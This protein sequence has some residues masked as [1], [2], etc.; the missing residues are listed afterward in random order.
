MKNKNHM[1]I[2]GGESRTVHSRGSWEPS[3]CPRVSTANEGSGQALWEGR[4][5]SKTQQAC[6]LAPWD[7]HSFHSKTHSAIWGQG[8]WS[9]QN[10]SYSYL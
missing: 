5:A 3:L 9:P 8:L 10:E 1:E 2:L 4:K 6:L 7:R